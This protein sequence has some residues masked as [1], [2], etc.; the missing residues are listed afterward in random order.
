METTNETYATN[1]ATGEEIPNTRQAFT[2]RE[3]A[4]TYAASLG[5]GEG[6]RVLTWERYPDGPTPNLWALIHTSN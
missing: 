3:D 2:N 5:T 1:R 4:K 6:Y